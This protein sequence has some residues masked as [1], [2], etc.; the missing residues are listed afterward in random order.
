MIWRV[1][2]LSFG[3]CVFIVM[4]SSQYI[5][6]LLSV[7]AAW[8]FAKHQ[9]YG[10]SLT[11][12]HENLQE[13]WYTKYT[14]DN[15]SDV[16]SL[17]TKSRLAVPND[18]ASVYSCVGPKAEDFPG[19]NE[20]LTF[21]QLWELNEPVIEKANGG[22]TYNDELQ[23]AIKEVASD[24]KVDARLILAIIMQEVHT[25]PIRPITMHQL[26]RPSPAATSPSTAQKRP[27]AA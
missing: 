19:Q 26:T 5:P 22:S 4:R 9:G 24:S 16:T 20:W 1:D 11:Q 14:K 27:P 12:L 10:T 2:C 21:D 25:I 17:S 13:A 7:A 6:F 18:P 15:Q 23:T 8:P 3:L